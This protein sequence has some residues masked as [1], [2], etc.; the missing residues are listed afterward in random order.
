MKKLAII[1][2]HP[3]QYNA[4]WFR[5]LAERRKISIRVFYTWG[6][7]ETESKYDPGFGKTIKWDIPVLDGYEYT[8]VKNVSKDPGS[9]HYR[10]I[11]NPSLIPEIEQWRPDALLV[12][13]WNFKSHIRCIRHFH[14]RLPVFF[15]GDSTL[16]DDEYENALKQ[17]A[18]K[19]WLR[20]LYKNIDT[21]FYTG[22]ASKAYFQY[23][24]VA[25]NK[26]A[27]APHAIDNERF[28]L[29]KGMRRK[30]WGIPADAFVFLFA[31]KLE[32]KKDPSLLLEAFREM[33]DARSFLL[34]VG[35]GKLESTLKERAQSMPADTANR[36]K[37]AGFQNQQAMPGVYSMADVF[38]LPSKGPGETWGLSVN[39][40]MACSRPVLVSDQCGCSAD[41]VEDSVNGFVFHSGDTNDLV[42]KM[43]K[44]ITDCQ[45]QKMGEASF[46]KIQDWSFKKICMAIEHRLLHQHTI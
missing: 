24:G 14:R 15:R 23:Y 35:N 43:K 26:L 12:I 20:W 32:P 38:V 29:A 21:V 9:H 2:T 13:G 19:I 18:K 17:L 40:A 25:E 36:I 7:L 45:V 3:I 44:L 42:A 10:G 1:T 30:E 33:N 11:D 39:E 41:L 6:Q 31:G 5:L 16:L 34:I 22:S 37:F 27:F 28:A 46:R 4:P 8:F